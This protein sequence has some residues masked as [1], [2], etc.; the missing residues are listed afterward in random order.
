MCAELPMLLARSI[1]Q[2]QRTRG[3]RDGPN[4]WNVQDFGEDDISLDKDGGSGLTIS[5]V[6]LAILAY[7]SCETNSVI[8]ERILH[9]L[10]FQSLSTSSG[11]LS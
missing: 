11:I 3:R 5:V 7:A 8:P 6:A 9:F 4:G 2:P 1:P 10:S